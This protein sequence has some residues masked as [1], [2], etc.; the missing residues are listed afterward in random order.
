MPQASSIVINDGQTTPVATTF[1]PELVTP[2]E[3]TFADRS[4]GISSTF[5]R[6][7]IGAKFSSG[8]V[9]VTRFKGEFPISHVTDGKTIVDSVA[10]FD[11]KLMLP[12]DA[13]DAQRKDVFAFLY[14]GLNHAN[15]KATVRDLDPQY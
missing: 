6:L 7:F 8:P 13:T 3:S 12:V 5:R 2:L 14:N 1:T 10:R 11:C 15:V 4:S 9:N